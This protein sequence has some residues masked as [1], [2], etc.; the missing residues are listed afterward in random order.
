MFC[1]MIGGFAA[2]VALTYGALGGVYIAGGIAPR[3]LDFLANS[4]FRR[5]FEE[6][7]RLRAYLQTIPSQVIVHPAATFLG[8]TSLALKSASHS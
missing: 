7:G 1:A 3:I 4:E 5:R 6:K 2:N 8:L